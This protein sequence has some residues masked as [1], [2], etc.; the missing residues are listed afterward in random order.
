MIIHR[1]GLNRTSATQIQGIVETIASMDPI[2]NNLNSIKVGDIMMS[3]QVD[4][5]LLQAM[6]FPI[7]YGIQVG[8]TALGVLTSD[9]N[10]YTIGYYKA[11]DGLGGSFSSPDAIQKQALRNGKPMVVN[12]AII[13]NQ[14]GVDKLKGDLEGVSNWDSQ[15]RMW[16]NTKCEQFTRTKRI[17]Q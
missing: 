11:K 1:N 3:L 17:L 15:K 13:L 7:K 4:Q 8:H 9:G 14:D 16:T 5:S 10:F 2:Q 12:E 6:G